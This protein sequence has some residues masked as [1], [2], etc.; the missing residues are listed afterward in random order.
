MKNIN[1]RSFVFGL[2][3]VVVI[4]VAIIALSAW[5]S[6]HLLD[7]AGSIELENI[8]LV[9]LSGGTKN[10]LGNE[11]QTLVYFFAPWCHVCS[12][13]IGKVDHLD[14]VNINIVTVVMDYQSVQEVKLFVE[15]NQVSSSVLLG[16]KDLKNTFNI[17]EYP[18]YYL[19]NK[20]S[21]VISSFYG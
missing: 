6:R 1:T 13:S 18:T 16:M 8:R 17:N 10:L 5:Q 20:Q 7:S 3:D 19:L 2:R 21:Q 9:E 15:S 4:V 12:L 11:K 14:A